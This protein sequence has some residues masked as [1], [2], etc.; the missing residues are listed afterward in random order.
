MWMRYKSGLHTVACC[1]M[2]ISVT[3]P[4][5]GCLWSESLSDDI[6]F[7]QDGGKNVAIKM[8][9]VLEFSELHV[10]HK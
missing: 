1:C 7:R 2:H 6:V 5:A 9:N 4:H 10:F 3:K 8:V